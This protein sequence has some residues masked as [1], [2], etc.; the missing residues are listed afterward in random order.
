MRCLSA[1]FVLFTAL[2][3]PILANAAPK[4]AATPPACAGRDLLATMKQ[5]DPEGY[6]KV[7]AAADAVPNARSLL[8]R[9]ERKG[10][11]PSYLFGTIH[12]TDPRVTKLP[13]AVQAAFNSANTVALE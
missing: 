6:A 12:S 4:N 5:S 10:L 2:L 9:V 11:A 3:A 13:P 8:W 7:R 1:L